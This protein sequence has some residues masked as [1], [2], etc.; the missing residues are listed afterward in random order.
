VRWIWL[1]QPEQLAVDEKEVLKKLLADDPEFATG[2]T[3]LNRFRSLITASN[4]AVLGIWLSDAQAI[5]IAPFVEF[6]NN[7][8][9]D[10]AA[11]K[12]A[13]ATNWSTGPVEGL[14]HRVK[15]I[16]RQGDGRAKLDLLRRRV[17][18]A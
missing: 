3:L 6:A 7:I 11:V 2:H 15:P 5:D 9:A 16:K 14:V 18:A 10:R 12:A 4:G 17:L 8:G 1:R 13:L